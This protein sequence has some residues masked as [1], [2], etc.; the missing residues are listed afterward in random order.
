MP[1][2]IDNGRRRLVRARIRVSHPN[3]SAVVLEREGDGLA[4][5]GLDEAYAHFEHIVGRP[6]AAGLQRIEE[7]LDGGTGKPTLV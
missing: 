7:A 3:V 2:D 4:K 6:G 1:D 5:A